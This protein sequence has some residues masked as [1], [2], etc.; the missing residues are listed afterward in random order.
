MLSPQVEQKVL[1]G[2]KVVQVADRSVEHQHHLEITDG[3]SS[4]GDP[5][6]EPWCWR[7][8]PMEL[9][10]VTCSRN[11]GLE[12]QSCVEPQFVV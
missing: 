1:Q 2:V 8:V 9:T 12:R 7:R 10:L 3:C 6:V 4:T 11:S 5:T